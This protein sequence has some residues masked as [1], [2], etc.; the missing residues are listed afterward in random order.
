MK[1]RILTSSQRRRERV[2][3]VSV[4]LLIIGI[5]LRHIDTCFFS[6]IGKLYCDRRKCRTSRKT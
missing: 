3:D 4:L 1:F 2:F 5:I 6:L